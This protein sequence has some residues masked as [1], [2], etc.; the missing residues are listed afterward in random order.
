MKLLVTGAGGLIGGAV[1]RAAFAEG[2][3][4]IACGRH[5]PKSLPDGVT[6]IGADLTDADA[7]I[8]LIDGTAPTH[9][10]HAAWETGQPSYWNDPVNLDWVVATAAMAQAFARVGGKRFLQV[11]SCA[12]YGWT[13]TLPLVDGPAT[14]YGK[15]KLAAFRAIETAAHDAFAA[16]EARIFWVYGPGENPARYI[17]LI[18]R[19]HAAGV[20]P[21]LGSGQQRR[22]LVH[23]DDA[24]RALLMLLADGAPT[25]VVDIGTGIGTLLADVAIEVAALAGVFETGLGHTP[26]RPGDPAVLVADPNALRSTG[27]EPRIILRHGLSRLFDDWRHKRATA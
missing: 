18:C 6:C 2:I 1:A 15:A 12:E 11:G 8:A 7:A 27:W 25:G 4:V 20:V 5:A 24:V 17:P 3:E 26:D 23:I 10:V 9:V 22:D 14:R 13:D 16:V 21:D 19:S